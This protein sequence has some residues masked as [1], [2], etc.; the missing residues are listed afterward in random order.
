MTALASITASPRCMLPGE[1]VR[2]TAGELEGCG[3]TVVTDWRTPDPFQV[4]RS[5]VWVLTDAGDN[6]L[7]FHP[8]ELGPTT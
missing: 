4:P 6:P 1:R 7:P 5:C 8:D 3:A 2:V